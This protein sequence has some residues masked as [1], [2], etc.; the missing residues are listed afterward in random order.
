MYSPPAAPRSIGGVID[1]AIRLYRA[2]FSRCWPL[3]LVGAVLAGIVAVWQTRELAALPLASLATGGASNASLAALTTLMARVSRME[4]SP[5][6]WLNYFVTMAVWLVFRAAIMRRQDAVASGREDSLGEALGYVLRQLPTL[7]IAGIVFVIA[8]T[9]GFIFLVVPGIWL[10]GY[11]Q[12][13]LVAAATEELGP[14]GALGR[15]WRLI[16]HHWWRTSATV[17]VAWIIVLVIGLT[18]GVFTGIAAVFFRG[19]LVMLL[20]V[21]QLVAAVISV[22]TMPMLTVAMVAI[23]HD[24]KLRREGGDLAARVSSLQPA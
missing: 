10:W 15:S 2:S 21:S 20:V 18:S 6:L 12:L 24:L 22:F 13:W 4:H 14:F 7:I 17:A 11:L 5:L 9:V 16:E 8:I 23:F 3:S 19:D 1:D